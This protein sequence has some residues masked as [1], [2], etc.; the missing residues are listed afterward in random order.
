MKYV[1]WK[2]LKLSWHNQIVDKVQLWSW[3]LDPWM[4]RYLPPLSPSC[5]Y[6]WNMKDVHVHWKL[7]NLSCQYQTKYWQNSVVTL[8]FNFLTPKCILGICPFHNPEPMY[9]ICQLSVENYIYLLYY[10]GTKILTKFSFDLL[11]WP[12]EPKMYRYLPLA[13]LHLCMKYEFKAIRWKL[14]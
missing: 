6:V 3:L 4:Y 8:T 14:L 1:R 13:I 5:T 12:F 7:L 2:L 9:E 10:V 11:F